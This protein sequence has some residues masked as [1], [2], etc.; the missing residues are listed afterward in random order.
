MTKTNCF[1][2][3]NRKNFDLAV[4]GYRRSASEVQEMI[5]STPGC[6]KEWKA[7]DKC[8]SCLDR[9]IYGDNQ[10]DCDL[11]KLDPFNLIEVKC[12]PNN[13]VITIYTN[14]DD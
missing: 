12:N 2:F 4:E 13:L 8:L 11:F 1:K 6:N 9:H 5:R 10:L 7:I 14:S 3:T